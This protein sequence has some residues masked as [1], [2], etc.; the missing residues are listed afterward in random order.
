MCSRTRFQFLFACRPLLRD[1][2]IVG[3]ALLPAIAGAQQE[4]SFKRKLVN[5]PM[6][7]YPTLARTMALSGLVKVEALVAADGTVK[8]VTIKGGHPVLAQAAAN[9]V[10]QWK[11]EAT[12][13]ESHELIEIRFSPPE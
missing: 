7:Q 4:S 1:T 2:L 10:R 11:W 8:A 5:H 12:S 3:L 13:H 9:T 6:A